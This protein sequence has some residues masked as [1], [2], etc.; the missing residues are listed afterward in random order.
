MAMLDAN[1]AN[2]YLNATL[3]NV[4]YTTVTGTHLRLGT[5][6]PT[7]GSNA[8]ELTGTGYT[9]GGTSISWNMA[10]GQAATN[11]GAVS[12]TNGS[13]SSWG[14][15]SDEVWDIAG[16][17]KRHLWGTWT[18]QPISVSN[19]NIFAVAAAAVSASIV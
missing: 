3:G 7:A 6:V 1:E 5:T 2:A 11:S 9:A 10:S 15:V 13:G 17:P 14:I 4:V 18:G 8:T 12:W 16:T 19:G